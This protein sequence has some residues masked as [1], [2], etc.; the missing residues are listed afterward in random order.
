MCLLYD[1]L[2]T[3]DDE[4]S[5]IWK[6]KKTLVFP[7]FIA[8]RYLPLMLQMV[9]IPL[10]FMSWQNVTGELE[11]QRMWVSVDVSVSSLML[12]AF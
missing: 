6:R 4:A 9:C 8:M 11:T 2:L 3:L 1:I 10:D 7:V 5:L 12:R